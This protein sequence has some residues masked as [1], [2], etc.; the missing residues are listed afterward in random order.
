[1]PENLEINSFDELKVALDSALRNGAASPEAA[2]YLIERFEVLCADID[3]VFLAISANDV[4]EYYP[5]LSLDEAR[6]VRDKAN[7]NLWNLGG[8]DKLDAIAW[9]QIKVEVERTKGANRDSRSKETCLDELVEAYGEQGA[10]Q[11]GSDSR[12]TESIP[13]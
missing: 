7:E 1:M 11:G 9:G 6:E 10:C 3:N 5:N 12:D 13:R 2:D 4:K 8:Y